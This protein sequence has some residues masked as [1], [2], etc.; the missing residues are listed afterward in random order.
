M[1]MHHGIP[2]YE[3]TVV[4]PLLSVARGAIAFMRQHSYGQVFVDWGS[5]L[6]LVNNSETEEVIARL[7]NANRRRDP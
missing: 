7:I 6:T 4:Y 5:S 1:R 3:P 2:V